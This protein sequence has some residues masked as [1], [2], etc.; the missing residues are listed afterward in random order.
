MKFNCY[1]GNGF[2]LPTNK[3]KYVLPEAT[4]FC[5]TGCFLKFLNGVEKQDISVPMELPQIDTAFEEW[6]PL[7]NCFYRSKYEKSVVLWFIKNNIKFYYESC[8][9]KI[10]DHYYTPDFWLPEKNI[11]IEVKGMWHF[12]SKYKTKKALKVLPLYIL[13]GYLQKQFNKGETE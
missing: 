10:G 7:T 1:C 8:S 6:E 5:S 11:L 4:L 13:P 12:G 2:T 3:C 9:F